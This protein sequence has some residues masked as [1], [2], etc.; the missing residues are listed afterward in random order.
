ML[1]LC[2]ALAASGFPYLGP[3]ITGCI[4]AAALLYLGVGILGARGARFDV[5]SL[6]WWGLLA[7][8]AAALVAFNKQLGLPL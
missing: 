2:A 6:I 4:A 1:A 5:M 7:A 3:K 8:G